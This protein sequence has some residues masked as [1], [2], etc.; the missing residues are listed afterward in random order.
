LNRDY[1][2]NAKGYYWHKTKKKWQAQISIDGKLK[3]LGYFD[4]EH[5]A[6][7]A[8]LEAKALRKMN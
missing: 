8:F 7:T 6:R 5:E 2:D 4:N 3:H 1:C